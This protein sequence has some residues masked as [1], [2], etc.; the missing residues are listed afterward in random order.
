MKFPRLAT[1]LLQTILKGFNMI[2]TYISVD[3]E[4]REKQELDLIHEEAGK[5]TDLES[6]GWFDGLIGLEPSHPE[7]HSYWS[8]YQI[9]YREYWAKKLKVEIPTEF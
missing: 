6:A 8:G 1:T 9:G 7:K 3:E 2:N 4:N 5:N